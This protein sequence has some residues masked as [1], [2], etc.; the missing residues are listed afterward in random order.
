MAS[1]MLAD[2]RG[3]GGW[4]RWQSSLGLANTEPCRVL[5][6]LPDLWGRRFGHDAGPGCWL[7]GDGALKRYFLFSCSNGHVSLLLGALIRPGA[8]PEQDVQLKFP[9]AAR[10]AAACEEDTACCA[11]ECERLAT[12]VRT[13]QRVSVGCDVESLLVA[14]GRAGACPRR[15]AP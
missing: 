4:M 13:G 12:N 5:G 8:L 2:G 11:E 9:T 1:L 3:M 7:E 10:P 15:P 14:A 6:H